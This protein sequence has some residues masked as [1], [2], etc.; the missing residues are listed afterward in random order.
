MG[1]KIIKRFKNELSYSVSVGVGKGQY[2]YYFT[3]NKS[4]KNKDTNEWEES[5]FYGMKDVAALKQA[6]ESAIRFTE[7][8]PLPRQD[9]QQPSE[10]ATSPLPKSLDDD[11]IPF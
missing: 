10:E 11:E 8:N 7:D 5:A 9:R 6:L 3:F 2:G 4:R 1:E